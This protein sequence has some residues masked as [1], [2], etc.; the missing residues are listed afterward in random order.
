MKS[1]S[2]PPEINNLKEIRNNFKLKK[3][4]SKYE[5]IQGFFERKRLNF[6]KKK[7]GLGGGFSPIFRKE[8]KGEIKEET[9]NKDEKKLKEFILKTKKDQKKQEK[10]DFVNEDKENEKYLKAFGIDLP[11]SIVEEIK[12]EVKLEGI[13]EE[14]KEKNGDQIVNNQKNQETDENKNDL[15]NQKNENLVENQAN[16]E[17]DLKELDVVKNKEDNSKVNLEKN[18]I[19]LDE[20]KENNEENKQNE[21]DSKKFL[22]SLENLDTSDLKNQA[23]SIENGSKH[24]ENENFFQE[25]ENR[26]GDEATAP[27]EI[28]IRK[29]T[30]E[31]LMGMKPPVMKKAIPLKEKSQDLASKNN[32]FNMSIKESLDNVSYFHSN[33]NQ[34]GDALNVPCRRISTYFSNVGFAPSLNDIKMDERRKS[35]VVIVEQEEEGIKSSK[36]IGDENEEE[37]DEIIGE[38][39]EEITEN[40]PKKQSANLKNMITRNQAAISKFGKNQKEEKNNGNIDE[41]P[42]ENLSE[43]L[44]ENL[45]ENIGENMG[46][47]KMLEIMENQERIKKEENVENIEK[48]KREINETEKIPSPDFNMGNRMEIKVALEGK[49]KSNLKGI[50]GKNRHQIRNIN[51]NNEK[52]IEEKETEMNQENEIQNYQNNKNELKVA[53]DEKIIKDTINENEFAKIQHKIIAKNEEHQIQEKFKTDDLRKVIVRD[54]QKTDEFFDSDQSIQNDQ[55][56]VEENPFS[57]AKSKE[58]VSLN[59]YELKLDSFLQKSLQKEEPI[60]GKIDFL[61]D[62]QKDEF[63]SKKSQIQPLDLQISWKRA[64][65]SLH[66]SDIDEAYSEILETGELEKTNHF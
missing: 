18:D 11:K 32:I 53:N 64:L 2:N 7:S 23:T 62:F 37:E 43:N 38:K 1:P 65:I 40:S 9:K 41:N 51:S 46:E 26:Q 34:S 10:F 12:Q 5:Q 58:G 39:K 3:G 63:H 13:E 50:I 14:N 59:S 52:I 44:I 47:N 66:N 6:V 36:K 42:R 45:G 55:N 15:E 57:F 35:H 22:D 33:A 48:N 60:L 30:D 56:F 16:V 29:K 28:P 21:Q 19:N 20:I 31:I 54:S 17:K 61:E 49:N 27:M 25:E 24:L 4:E 8:K